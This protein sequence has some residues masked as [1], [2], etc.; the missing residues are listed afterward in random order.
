[1]KYQIKAGFEL[2]E[3]AGEFLLLPRGASTVDMNYVTVFNETGVLLYRSL[4]TPSDAET[5][6]T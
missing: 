3:M 5:L 1:M 4:Q 6:S 2:K